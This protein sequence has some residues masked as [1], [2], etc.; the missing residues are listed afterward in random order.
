MQIYKESCIKTVNF[1]APGHRHYKKH[2]Q[3]FKYDQQ[4]QAGIKQLFHFKLTVLL[5][6]KFTAL[7]I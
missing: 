5:I 2:V 3:K 4:D 6:V 1:L 7:R